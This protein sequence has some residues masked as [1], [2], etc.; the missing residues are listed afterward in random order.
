MRLKRFRT[1]LW[2]YALLLSAVV[3][4]VPPALMRNNLERFVSNFNDEETENSETGA[5][6]EERSEEDTK[7]FEEKWM[8][9]QW[10]LSLRLINREAAAWHDTKSAQ[11]Y[12]SP[13]RTITSPPPEYLA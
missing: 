2:L 6:G 9:D 4:T 11:R 7:A 12:E 1:G 5:D 8:H 13:L 3:A 10:E